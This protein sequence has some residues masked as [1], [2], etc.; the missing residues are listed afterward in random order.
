[1]IN[2]NLHAYNKENSQLTSYE[3]IASYEKQLNNISL[4]T[5]AQEK[6]KYISEKIEKLLAKR[7]KRNDN[8][9]SENK[10]LSL[11]QATA[12]CMT[13][14]WNEQ[15]RVNKKLDVKTFLDAMNSIN[16]IK[17]LSQDISDNIQGISSSKVFQV[18]EFTSSCQ[19]KTIIS[20]SSNNKNV[21]LNLLKKFNTQEVNEDSSSLPNKYESKFCEYLLFINKSYNSPLIHY[22]GRQKKSNKILNFM[23]AKLQLNQQEYSF[24]I[25]H[26]FNSH[27]SNSEKTLKEKNIGLYDDYNLLISDLISS[28]LQSDNTNWLDDLAELH[29]VFQHSS[30]VTN[31]TSDFILTLILA[32]CQIKGV[33]FNIHP[34]NL[35]FDCF[36]SFL[37]KE[38]I[39]KFKE[40]FFDSAAKKASMSL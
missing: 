35:R 25:S 5:S 32:I 7:F 10:K 14:I 23:S 37:N 30:P 4:L 15:L 8:S 20:K 34:T 22:Y 40:Q 3:I 38:Y 17:K 16:R 12:V 29:W 19:L 26:G 33:T 1:M 18:R 21:Y 9:T 6:A 13:L 28:C 11:S 31:D 2:N 24:A 39:D 36:N 27:E